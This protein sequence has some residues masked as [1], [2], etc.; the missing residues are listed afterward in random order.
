MSAFSILN[1]IFV[2]FPGDFIYFLLVIILSIASLLMAMNLSNT[3]ENHSRERYTLAMAGVAFAWGLMLAGVFYSRVTQQG[4]DA[5]LPP[6]ERA[7]STSSILLIGWALLT[8]D[9][10]RWHR[11]SNF[12]LLALLALVTAGY[13]MTGVSWVAQADTSSG[14]NTTV[15]GIGWV[16]I[17]LVMT[18][19]GL[20]LAIL[21]YRNVL[22]APLKIVFFL[23][24]G[25]GASVT[26]YQ[27]IY[28][29]VQ[30]GLVEQNAAG[31]MRLS[32]ALALFI[33]P[34]LMYR[35]VILKY[36]TAIQQRSATPLPRQSVVKEVATPTAPQLSPMEVQSVQ[37]LKA[38]GLILE[39]TTPN[40]IPAQVVRTTLN[41]LHADVGALLRLQDAN[42][43]DI[44][45]AY[46]QVMQNTPAGLSLNLDDQPTLV[47][48]IERQSQRALY[49]DRNKDELEDLYTRMDIEQMGPVYF[50]PLVHRREVVAVLLIA[51][52]YTNRELRTEEIELLKGLGIVSSNLLAISYE[53]QEAALLAEDRVIQ[54]MVEGVSPSEMQESSVLAARQEMQ[55]SLKFARDQ[56]TQLSEQVAEMKIQLDHERSRVMSLLGDTEQDMSISQRIVVITD[57]QTQLRD[58]R[59]RLATRL[60]ESEAALNGAIATDN[61]SV[62][63]NMVEALNYEK[64][65]LEAEKQHLQQK[66]TEIRGQSDEAVPGDMQRLLNKMIEEKRRLEEDRY[67]L[68]DKLE[69]IHEQLKALGI[70]EGTT[71]GLSQLIGS[72]YEER[73]TLRDQNQ[74]LQNERDMLLRERGEFASNIVDSKNQNEQVQALQNELENL[75]TDRESAVKQRNKLR[76]DRDELEQK[77]NAVKQHR[78]RLLAEVSGYEIELVE[79][80]EEQMELRAEIQELA[81]GRSELVLIRDNLS[82]H[83]H[84]LETERDQLLAQIEGDPRRLQQVNEEGIG[85]MRRMIEDLSQ[86]RDRLTQELNEIKTRLAEADTKPEKTQVDAAMINGSL[87]HYQPQQPELL[88]GLVQELRTPMTSISGYVDLL[89]GETVGILGEMQRDFLRRVRANI[90]R[91]GTM[92]DSLIN[93]TELDTGNYRLDPRPINVVSLVE[94]AITN[95]SIQFR[96]KGLVVSLDLE[97]NMPDLPGDRDA[98]NQIIGQLLTNAY[99][100]SPQDSEILVTVGRRS[101][102]LSQ[103]GDARPCL[104]VAIEDKGGG[105]DPEDVPRVFA[106]KYK[107]NNPLVNGLGD[108][109]VGLSIAKALVE[110]HHGRLWVETKIGVGSTLAFAIPLDTA[111]EIE[112]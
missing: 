107:A 62:V 89:L 92:I 41:S 96:Q 99:L 5:I 73:A 64:A 60:Q 94:D 34:V 37:L 97:D 30:A 58:E 108:T 38:L 52:P 43:A 93:V 101:V 13:T 75:A 80:R 71:A 91:L 54:A 35:L 112:E 32:F 72:L 22:D 51:L 65:K 106:R 19:L 81:D 23:L 69:S 27:T 88:V 8:A 16:F 1:N 46:D 47:N 103:D 87:P 70:E 3:D 33:V 12:V 102:R 79:A 90:N 57:E 36:E 53:A 82:A 83:N 76:L 18:F 45:E 24:I 100:V 77:L 15:Y 98:M 2:D 11:S 78:A 111:F 28:Q 14:F 63:H 55:Q 48:A 10:Q 31:I 29:P 40:E 39:A 67:Q 104:Y 9:H 84:E 66:L 44:T 68:V 50:Q 95:A 26:L 25:A 61:E 59:D 21:L 56:I 74:L 4:L 86:E 6:L 110:A 42:Y 7:V 85:S 17:P 20:I 105:I 49:P 109:G